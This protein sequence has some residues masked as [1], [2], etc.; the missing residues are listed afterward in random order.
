M[1][2][3]LL[4]ATAFGLIAGGAQAAL[5][6]STATSSLGLG[7]GCNTTNATGVIS[8]SCSGGGFGSVVIGASAAPTLPNGD[9]SALT[10]T[11]TNTSAPVTLN[12]GIAS[13]GFAAVNGPFEAVFT[14]NDLIGAD[15]GP[16]TLSVTA[17]DG[18]VESHTFTGSGT[19]DTGL[20]GLGSG[21]SDNAHF[22]LAF[23]AVGQSLDATI[24]L[25]RQV[26]EPSTLALMGVGLLGL[27][28]LTNRKRS[29]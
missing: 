17:P 28:F 18:T 10:L 24:E 13:S 2:K 1:R 5:I 15:T 29:A 6:T 12:V 9:I 11:V 16:F 26:P 4:A 20:F 8:T 7:T 19:F 3:L 23:T 25:V 27:G 22:T 14:T 21:T